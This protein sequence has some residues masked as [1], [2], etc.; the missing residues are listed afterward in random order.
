MIHLKGA[1][2][3][4]GYLGKSSEENKSIT[5]DGW[6]KTGDIGRVTNEGFLVIEGRLSRF[7]KIG[8][9]MISH[10]AIENAVNTVLGLNDAE[11]RK[12]AIVGIPDPKKGEEIILL[13]SLPENQE[14]SL[15]QQTVELRYKLMDTGVP[16][17]W[18]PKHIIRVYE[19]PI[20]A[21][22]KL[23]LKSCQKLAQE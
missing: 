11:E 21:S 1:N 4:S 23:D 17:L 13:T 14:L 3:F 19:I 22:G 18:C 12:I 15:E 7:S 9:E 6:F 20:L 16:A 2:V 8:G 10:E 5:Q